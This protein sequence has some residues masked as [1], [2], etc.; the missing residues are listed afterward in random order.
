LEE[1]LDTTV[2]VANYSH[3]SANHLQHLHY[4]VEYL[5]DLHPD[6]VV[7]YGGFNETQGTAFHDPRPGYPHNYF[8]SYE[9]PAWKKWLIKHSA[10]IGHMERH[11]LRIAGLPKL[12]EDTGLYS[13]AWLEDIVLHY[14]SYMERGEQLAEMTAP[15]HQ[16]FRTPFIGIYQPYQ[17]VPEMMP[18]HERI[19]DSFSQ[20]VELFDLSDALQPLGDSVYTDV[21]H[22]Q[23]YGRD[24]LAKII[25][26]I[27]SSQYTGRSL[28]H[29]IP[30]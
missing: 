9:V 30:E 11:G 18:A 17:V 24:H 29:Q 27:I 4:Y 26:D 14:L 13:E 23:Q 12:R 22:V 2:Y 21:V 15:E 19:R 20:H 16:L 25:A 7:F 28:P 5:M 6:L 1:E 10:L 3:I 8:F